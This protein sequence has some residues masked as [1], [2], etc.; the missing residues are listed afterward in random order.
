MRLM[1]K[2][3]GY[4]ALLCGLSMLVGRMHDRVWKLQMA[5]NEHPLLPIGA[6][7]WAGLRGS[8]FGWL[9][10]I[11][12]LGPLLRWPLARQDMNAMMTEA[13]GADWERQV[14]SNV[15]VAPMRLLNYSLFLADA[16]IERN[17]PF[18][19]TPQ[20]T[21]K[22]DFYKPHNTQ[23]RPS[24][25]IIVIH[26]GGW[27]HGDKG[28]WFEP[29]NRY[30]AAC[31]YAVFDVQYRFTATD[32]TFWPDQ[33]ADI[34]AAIRYVKAHAAEYG[35]DPERIGLIGRSAG[36]QLALQAAYRAEGADAD[37]A[38]Q[39]VIGIY[40]PGNLFITAQEHD[41][42]VVK[43]LGST[44]YEDPPIYADASP[45]TH[46]DENSPPTL[47][48]HGYKDTLVTPIHSEMLLNRLRQY[49]RPAAFLRVPWARHGF[50]AVPFGMGAFL[51]QYYVDRFLA[52]TLH[53]ETDNER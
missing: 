36:A 23:S 42:R 12:S 6:G 7:V 34:R 49:Q 51:V 53:A 3:L 44:S 50:D 40:T 11:L 31:G 5:I 48:I 15:P 1:I 20:R 37:T 25:V 46:I 27:H 41:H 16:P 38:V 10:A 33:L 21:L 14:P 30:L 26:G 32:H 29:H 35:V 4:F 9:G 47:L 24:P 19:E 28:G 45:I 39:T 43:F 52:I 22:L 8:R 2:L 17:V 13:F 18:H